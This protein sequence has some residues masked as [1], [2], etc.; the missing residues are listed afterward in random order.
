MT[1]DEIKY[2]ED[3]LRDVKSDG[4]EE[5]KHI[6]RRQ[7]QDLSMLPIPQKAQNTAPNTERVRDFV[8]R[9]IMIRVSC[10][11]ELITVSQVLGEHEQ[12]YIDKMI[13]L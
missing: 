1:Q 5:I 12:Q 9:K 6:L 7:E 10:I 11:L 8:K 3:Y 2:L 4:D 13:I